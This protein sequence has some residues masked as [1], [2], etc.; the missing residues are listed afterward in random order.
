M[1]RHLIVFAIIG[2]GCYSGLALFGQRTQTWAALK[3]FPLT[4]LPW[5]LGL[6]SL[7]YFL[8]YLRWQIYLHAL[9]ITIGYWK[10]LQIFLAGLT[11]TVTPAKLGEALKA[12]LLEGRVGNHWSKGLCIVFTERLTD[13][14]GVVILV[15]IGLT[16]LPVGREWVFLGAGLCLFLV[17]V[18]VHPGLFSTAVRLLGKLPRMGNLSLNLLEMHENVRR[19]MAPRL[20]TVA[21]PLSCAAWFAECLILYYALPALGGKISGL[22]ATFTYALSTLAG[23]LSFLPGGLVVTEG[24]MTGLLLLSG[25]EQSLAVSATFVV[26]LCTL[27]FAV[28]LGLVFLLIL[29]RKPHPEADTLTD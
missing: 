16:V 2:A 6:A 1:G 22:Q 12:H 27:W 8:R 17:V 20:I 25:L 13:L 15:A 4:H 18:S 28:F 5:L 19:L 14:M 29:Q 24:S 23:A 10:S 3:S 26:R 21:L 7:N 9:G 11:M